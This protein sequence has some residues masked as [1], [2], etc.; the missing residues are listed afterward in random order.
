MVGNQQAAGPDVNEFGLAF[1]MT[2][3]DNFYAY[4]ISGNGYWNLSKFEDGQ[5]ITL[6]DWTATDAIAPVGEVNRLGV[7]ADG[8]LLTLFV[9]GLQ[10]GQVNDGTF[11]EGA[12]A[13]LA[14]TFD[15]PGADIAFDNFTFWELTE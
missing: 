9:N 14:G 8:D 5:W 3:S 11:T 13:L 4:F 6:S 1:R 2:D 15:E 7:L 12:I 10:V